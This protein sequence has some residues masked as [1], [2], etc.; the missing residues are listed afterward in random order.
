[1]QNGAKETDG[2]E[3]AA[4]R[5]ISAIERRKEKP[6]EAE[7][8]TSS[9]KWLPQIF[10]GKGICWFIGLLMPLQHHIMLNSH[11]QTV[12]AYKAHNLTSA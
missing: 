2:K 12:K 7:C 10:V 8:R 4:E 1:M 6:E 11:K 5:V 3:N 9:G